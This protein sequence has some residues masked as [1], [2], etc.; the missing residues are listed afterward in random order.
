MPCHMCIDARIRGTDRGRR[1]R[2]WIRSDQ[3]TGMEAWWTVRNRFVGDDRASCLRVV[4]RGLVG[5]RGRLCF[6]RRGGRG[7]VV[8]DCPAA[9][10]YVVGPDRM[11]RHILAN[12]ARDHVGSSRSS[13]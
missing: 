13:A 1:D 6:C 3:V 5:G 7:H 11:D 8:A 2:Q 9:G 4:E 10:I 12:C